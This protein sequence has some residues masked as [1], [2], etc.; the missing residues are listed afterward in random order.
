MTAIKI[1]R[2]VRAQPLQA[3]GNAFAI[4]HSGLS[5]S[6]ARETTRAEYLHAGFSEI[7]ARVASGG[8]VV[9]ALRAFARR[10]SCLLTRGK[11]SFGGMSGLYYSWRKSP[12]AD[13]LMRRYLGANR[14]IPTE[15]L[16]EFLNRLSQSQL[17]SASAA[18]DSLRSDWRRGMPLPGLGI[19][20]H[21][22]GALRSTA[23]RFPFGRSQFY[24]YLSGGK[25]RS[26]QQLASAALRGQR[27]VRRREA[28]IEDCRRTLSAELAHE[29]LGKHAGE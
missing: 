13:T 11:L 3:K 4:G 19:W 16:I 12:T 14:K 2:T 22:F 28:F 7:A 10:R 27:D 24:A 1:A 8:S 17:G 21:Q 26:F 9:A 20:V 29:P 23:P 25:G 6:Q 5:T 15:L 18:F